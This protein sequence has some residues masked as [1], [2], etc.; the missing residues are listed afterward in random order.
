MA[1]QDSAPLVIARRI[2]IRKYEGFDRGYRDVPCD[3]TMQINVDKLLRYLG[4]RALR[5]KS[6]KSADVG[7]DVVCHVEELAS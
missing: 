4:E 7:G 2:H 3:V 1:K 6:K 5:N